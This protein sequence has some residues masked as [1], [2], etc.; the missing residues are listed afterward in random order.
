MKNKTIDD[1]VKIK[2]ATVQDDEDV[3]DGKIYGYFTE[4]VG[5]LVSGHNIY[6]VPDPKEIND[7]MIQN[8]WG[9]FMRYTGFSVED[10]LDFIERNVVNTRTTINLSLFKKD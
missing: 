10:I 2:F 3:K 6:L 5:N 1:F 7:S 8:Y 4:S 9:D